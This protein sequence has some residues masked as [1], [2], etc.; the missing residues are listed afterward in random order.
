MT[1]EKGS[2]TVEASLI[3]PLVILVF[4]LFFSMMRMVYIHGKMQL[5][6]NQMCEEFSYDSYLL[7][8]FEVF[9]EIQASYNSVGAESYEFEDVSAIA[10]GEYNFDIQALDFHVESPEDVF[11]VGGDILQFINDAHEI[12]SEINGTFRKEGLYFLSSSVGKAYFNSKISETV[13]RNDFEF[14]VTIEHLDI[15]I[16]DDQGVIVIS[17]PYDFGVGLFGFNDVVLKNSCGLQ[18]FSGHGEY[19]TKYHKALE[20]SSYGKGE[21]LVNTED[22]DGYSPI[23][24]RTQHGTKYHKNPMCFHIAVYPEM[25]L[26]SEVGATPACSLCGDLDI[27]HY[28]MYVYKTEHGDVYHTIPTCSKIYHLNITMTEKEALTKGLSPCGTCSQ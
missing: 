4:L 25:M 22:E 24:Y 13:R 9:D 28:N 11:T 26:L 1:D 2:I 12:S 5:E 3:L 27:G 14:E 15:G 8:N 7:E 21:K 20:A 10:A 23:V 19:N 16:S 18:L 6:L 17:Y